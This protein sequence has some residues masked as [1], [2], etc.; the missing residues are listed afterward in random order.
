[1]AFNPS[2]DV[3]QDVLNAADPSRAS[4]A[5]QRLNALASSNAPEADFSA[6]LD[7]VASSA[8]A[9]PA[10]LASAADARS[11]LAEMPNGSD[12]LNQ[13]KTQFE[14][15][16]LN[17]A[18]RRNAAERREQR[19]RLGNGRRHVAIDARGTGLAADR[20]IRQARPLQAL[21]RNAMS[22]R[23]ATG[24]RTRVRRSRPRATPPR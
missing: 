14:A 8:P 2:T 5:T 7:R 12:K 23:R 22:S 4:V 21:V 10:P 19:L 16:M 3:V 6:D 11:R 13:A 24:R 18:R 9:I 15:M 17:S 1:M 20:E